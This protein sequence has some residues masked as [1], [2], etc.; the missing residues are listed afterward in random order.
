MACFS[1]DKVASPAKGRAPP[2]L[3]L[4]EQSSRKAPK[5][6]DLTIVQG[7]RPPPPRRPAATGDVVVCLYKYPPCD[8]KFNAPDSLGEVLS[9]IVPEGCPEFQA[10]PFF[11][12]QLFGNQGTATTR[13]SSGKTSWSLLCRFG[14]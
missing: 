9:A 4:A 12:G 11:Q 8:V 3:P 1:M 10:N 14:R 6:T 5:V 2:P 13:V 7:P